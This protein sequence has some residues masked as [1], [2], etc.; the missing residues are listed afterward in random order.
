MSTRTK[1]ARK[2]RL[3]KETLRQLAPLDLRKAIGGA[4]FTCGA[5]PRRTNT[6]MP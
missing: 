4:T 3:S 1:F 2:L 6:C 5:C